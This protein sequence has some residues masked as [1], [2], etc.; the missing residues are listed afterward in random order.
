MNGA[1]IYQPGPMAILQGVQLMTKTIKVELVRER[2]NAYLASGMPH[3]GGEQLRLGVASLLETILHATNNYHGF[4][5]LERYQEGI[6]D[7]SRRY[8]R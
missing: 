8:Y 7:T 2:A 3:D 6:S 1:L 5:Y 4:L